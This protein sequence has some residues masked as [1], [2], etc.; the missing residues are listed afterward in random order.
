VQEAWFL[1]ATFER[2]TITRTSRQGI[3]T[4]RA[5][6]ALCDDYDEA[7]ELNPAGL[8]EPKRPTRREVVKESKVS[9]AHVYRLL[10]NRQDDQG[11]LGELIELGYVRDCES[12]DQAAVELTNH[13]LTV[14][15]DVPDFALVNAYEYKPIE[16]IELDDTTEI[17]LVSLNE[18]LERVNKQ[19]EGDKVDS[20][21]SH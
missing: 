5:I 8:H 11:K 20:H 12:N 19:S 3:A 21:D 15:E 17:P 1:L 10:R 9:Q 6:K 2:E 7:F 4:L 18:I 14:L 13:G 16:P